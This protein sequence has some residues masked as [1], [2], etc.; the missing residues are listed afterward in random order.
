LGRRDPDDFYPQRDIELLLT[1]GSQIG[2]ALESTRLFA[3][4]Q[5]RADELE[6]INFEL[7]RAIRVKN[8]M[9]RNVSH[10]LRTP[11]TAI[12]GYTDLLADGVAGDLS[13]DQLELLSVVADR[14]QDL[15]GMIN[16]LISYQ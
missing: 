7:H 11:L 16:D 1:L 6:R 5:Q 10:E 15:G 14:S 4:E 13:P 3:I 2:I 12:T 8:D 9:L